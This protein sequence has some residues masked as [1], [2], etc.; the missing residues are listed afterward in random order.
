MNNPSDTIALN[1]DADRTLSF[2]RRFDAPLALIREVYADPAHLSRW[3]GPEGFST[4]THEM[5]QRT[6]GHWRFTMHG[7]EG[8]D[9]PNFIRYREITDTSMAWDHGD[10]EKAVWFT[11]HVQFE[12][13][14]D[15]TYVTM[16]ITYPSVEALQEAVEKFGV[17]EGM[18]GT[19]CRLASLLGDLQDKPVGLQITTPDNMTIRM[20]RAFN[21]PKAMVYDAFSDPAKLKE[22]WGAHGYV[23]ELMESDQRVGGKWRAVQRGPKGDKFGFHGEILELDPPNR[24]VQTF[25]YDPMPDCVCTET[26]SFIE[27]YGKTIFVANMRF[28]SKAERDG[29]LESG[30]EVGAGES[31]ER[32]DALLQE[33]NQ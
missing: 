28:N 21:A 26:A 29:M 4:T 10:D 17:S 14:G 3:W 7:P 13:D 9:Y 16:S 1:T 31:Y 23:N 33:Q 20:T 12:A 6:G 11:G 19:Q 5:D 8:T 27:D 30:M 32:L 22:W 2:R 25:I 24:M 18:H 15:G